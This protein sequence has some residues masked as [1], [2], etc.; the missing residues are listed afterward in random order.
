MSVARKPLRMESA[1][2]SGPTVLSSSTITGAGSAP[3]L[4]MTARS[5]AWSGEKL[6]VICACPEGIGS[7]IMGADTT[8]P[9]RTMAS[10][11]PTLVAVTSE[12]IFAPFEFRVIET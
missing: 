1:P 2:K 12:K 3:A 8:F 9:S 5:L 6:P 11:L 4:S 7:R 10:L